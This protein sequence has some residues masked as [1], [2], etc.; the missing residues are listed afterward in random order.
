MSDLADALREAIAGQSPRRVAELLDGVPERERPALR[1]VLKVDREGLGRPAWAVAAAGLEGGAAA[2]AR[3][4]RTAWMPGGHQPVEGSTSSFSWW[5]PGW[6]V[7]ARVLLQRQVDWLPDLVVRLADAEVRGWGDSRHVLTERLRRELSLPR[8]TG[9]G[10]LRWAVGQW[11]G[12]PWQEDGLDRAERLRREPDPTALV[13]AVLAVPEIGVELQITRAA[14]TEEWWSPGW[15]EALLDLVADGTLARD[16]LLDALTA[17]LALG[18]SGRHQNSLAHLLGALDPT[19]E[20]TAAR[21]RDLCALLPEAAG[22]VADVVLRLGR[23]AVGAGA[24]SVAEAVETTAEALRR[25]EKGVV[26]AHLRWLAGLPAQDPALRDVVLPALS[27]AFGHEHHD[28]AQLAWAAVERLLP[29]AAE[30]VRADLLDRAAELPRDL[31]DEAVRVLGGSPGV[32][33]PG[34]PVAAAPPGEPA[35]APPAAPHPP[36]VQDLADLVVAITEHTRRGRPADAERVLDGLAR[37]GAQ[38][39]QALAAALAPAAESFS[40]GWERDAHFAPYPFLAAATRR[41]G[42]PRWRGE[43]PG[44][45]G[46]VPPGG[47][48]ILALRAREVV[49]RVRAGVAAPLLAFP[50]TA[51]GHVDPGRVLADLRRA[52]ATGVDPGPLDLEQT[53]LRYPR[54]VAD[55]EHLARLR[56][57]GTPA[58]DRLAQHLSPGGLPEAVVQPVPV[59]LQGRRY[60]YQ[61]TSEHQDWP[62]VSLTGSVVDTPLVERGFDGA[63][64]PERVVRER[65]SGGLAALTTLAVLPSHREVAAGELLPPLV[66]LEHRHDA[67]TTTTLALLPEAGGPTGR[68]THLALAYGLLSAD[69][70]VR[71][72]AVDAV[73]GF[74]VRGGLD[75]TAAGAALG[76]VLTLDEAKLVRLTR[77]LAP[78]AHDDRRGVREFTARYLLAALAPV[79]P[80]RRNGLSDLLALAADAAHGTG[81]HRPVP[82]LADLATSG[83]RSRNVTEARR[84]LAGLA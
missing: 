81:P 15:R 43:K 17:A 26:R 69:E 77:A 56:A 6:V 82:G 9:A 84:V 21:F 44:R 30:T 65:W 3:R 10:Y 28:L 68:A 53:W 54:D 29:G 72:G 51:L 67:A 16:P 27:E 7:V 2:V 58:A 70:R 63:D 33:V 62:L 75:A 52:A 64:L 71:L 32:T 45:P 47:T 57:V 25:R 8:P 41:P 23:A 80:L 79:V 36:R 38:H 83:G 18:G 1:V 12:V 22:T 11:F 74:A 48:G 78:L 35:T 42:S 31:Q 59:A 24:V 50:D 37:F 5:A 46:P 20:E 76:A 40:L 13:V 66:D 14:P 61:D 55:D 49:E 34:E 4:L 39:L 19:P 73:H 60:G